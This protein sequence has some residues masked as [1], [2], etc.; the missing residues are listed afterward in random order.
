MPFWRFLLRDGLPTDILSDVTYAVFGLGDTSYQRFC[1]PAR[2][3]GR[4]LQGLGAQELLPSGEADDQH[5]LGID[6]ALQPWLDDLWSTLADLLPLPA[7]LESIPDDVILP[8]HIEVRV[9]EGV[10]NGSVAT[11]SGS[12]GAV[13]HDVAKSNGRDAKARDTAPHAMRWARLTRN[14]RMT[15]E[16]HWQDVRQIEWETEDGGD[17]E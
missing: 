6:G 15:A 13:Q 1:W 14:E 12:N 10:D 16:D 3:L 5:Y 2:K 9:L 17:I 8:P 7:G 4:R 11:A